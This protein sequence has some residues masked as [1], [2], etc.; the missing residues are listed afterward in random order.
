[1]YDVRSNSRWLGW[2]V[3]RRP[4]LALESTTDW[5]NLLTTFINV[6][7]ILYVRNLTSLI[8]HVFS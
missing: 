1:M 3:V 4:R 6:I 5:S 8:F 2:R 7:N